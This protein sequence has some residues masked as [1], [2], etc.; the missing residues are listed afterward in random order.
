[1]VKLDLEGVTTQL[2]YRDYYQGRNGLVAEYLA[3][4][5][6]VAYLSADAGGG[7]KGENVY[8][9]PPVTQ[10]RDNANK[11]Y[12]EH[13]DDFY[14]LLVE[15]IGHVHK[16]ILHTT[17]SQSVPS[18]YSHH[19]ACS[20]SELVVPGLTVF[21]KEEALFA[22]KI[23]QNRAGK[24]VRLK[25]PDKSDGRD[26]FSIVN[27]EHLAGILGSVDERE[28]VEKGLVLETN[29]R[30]V[31]TVSVGYCVLG[32]QT[33]SFIALQKNDIAPEDGRDRYV[34][35]L[36]RVVKGNVSSLRSVAKNSKEEK[37]IE[38]CV[39]FDAQYSYFEPVASRISYDYLHGYDDKGNLMSGVTDITGRLGGTCPALV[40]SV[41][42]Y[43]ENPRLKVVQSEVSLNYDPGEELNCEV[44]AERFIDLQ[45]LRLTARINSVI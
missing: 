18:F 31:E 29:V 15:N 32:D 34:G 11:S 28:V 25:Y 22:H 8:Y 17:T 4:Y 41:M 39:K 38:A 35:A 12:I 24:E 2:P 13:V 43:K 1:M 37:A 3:D 44:G 16:A 6:G 36:V 7:P 21:T 30:D 23:M 14:G 10:A 45:P 42:E 20:V 33:Y 5:F 26:Q 27:R 19:F 40:M 9:V